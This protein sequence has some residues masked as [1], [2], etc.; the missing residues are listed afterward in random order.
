MVTALSATSVESSQRRKTRTCQRIAKN[1][2]IWGQIK[3]PVFV[4]H[5]EKDWIAPIDNATF[6][7]RYFTAA[8]LRVFR[9]AKLDHF[10]P[11]TKPHLITQILLN[12]QD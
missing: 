9:Y 7:E 5:G 4:L 10:I 12:K 8:N 6:A 1:V 11:F 3:Q 2:N